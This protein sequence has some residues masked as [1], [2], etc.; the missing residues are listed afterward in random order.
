MKA[1][2]SAGTSP[3]EP[4]VHDQPLHVRLGLRPEDRTRSVTL[5]V[6]VGDLE[7]A[8]AV[9]ERK[10]LPY[11]TLLKMLIHEGLAREER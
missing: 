9:A 3:E 10:G 2:R 11:Q 7:R 5:R 1:K 8:K 6:A 4:V